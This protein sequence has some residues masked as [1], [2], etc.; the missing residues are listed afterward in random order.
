MCVT[1]VDAHA[2]AHTVRQAGRQTG[3]QAGK[4]ACAYVRACVLCMCVCVRL[5]PCV[6]ALA[7]WPTLG[8]RAVPSLSCAIDISA[9]PRQGLQH[10]APRTSFVAPASHLTH[11]P[12]LACCPP[13]RVFASMCVCGLQVQPVEVGGTWAASRS[14]K[15]ST[16]P[17]SSGSNVQSSSSKCMVVDTA[18]TAPS[19]FASVA[20]LHGSADLGSGGASLPNTSSPVCTSPRTSPHALSSSTALS[21]SQPQVQPLLQAQPGSL[22]PAVVRQQPPEQPQPPPQLPAGGKP[23]N[24]ANGRARGALPGPAEKPVVQ[25]SESPPCTPKKRGLCGLLW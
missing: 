19:V 12:L 6:H 24:S 4:R 1:C 9:R 13:V 10:A 15:L 25:E 17:E 23:A 11:A 22:A 21:S 5:W 8:P 18:D 3:R 16:V 7:A 14:N 20:A 2:A